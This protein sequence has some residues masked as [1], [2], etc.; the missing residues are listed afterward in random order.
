MEENRKKKKRKILPKRRNFVFVRFFWKIV[1]RRLVKHKFVFLP[2]FCVNKKSNNK[3][4]KHNE[5]TH[6]ERTNQ[7]E[8]V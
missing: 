1:R 5:R 6:E 8:E 2:T 7:E 4:G 3:E